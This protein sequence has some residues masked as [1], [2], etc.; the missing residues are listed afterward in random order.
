[1]QLALH[2][3]EE[4]AL[5]DLTTELIAVWSHCCTLWTSSSSPLP[6]PVLATAPGLV[7]GEAGLPGVV[8]LTGLTGAVPLGSPRASG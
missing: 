7:E 1:M 4:L 2:A 5:F 6:V 8:D 3:L